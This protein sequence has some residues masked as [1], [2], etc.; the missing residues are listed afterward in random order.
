LRR[1]GSE[2]MNVSTEILASSP[3]TTEGTKRSLCLI[4]FAEDDSARGA[5]HA[6]VTAWRIRNLVTLAKPEITFMVMISAGFA[7]L[8]ASN[9][10]SIVVLLKTM[11]GTGLL[12]GGAGALNQYFERGLD[13]RMRRTARR[14]LPSGKVTARAALFLG[15][16]L[17]LGGTIY[18][19]LSLNVL[20]ALL[21]FFTL[22]TYVFVYTPLKTRTTLSTVVGAIPGAAPMLMGW[23][24]A[25]NGLAPMAWVLFFIL[26]F[27]QFPHFY[28]IGWLYREDYARAGMKMLPAID[29]DGGDETFRRIMISTQLLIFA[30][31]LLAFIASLGAVYLV[32]GLSLGLGFYYVAYRAYL[33]RSRLAAKTLLHASVLYLPLLYIVILLDRL[34]LS[35]ATR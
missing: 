11:L 10:F 23:A 7:C 20:T 15:V 13:A 33:S 2:I 32:L 22:V 18:L 6:S 4:G 30:S 14:P 12:A 17:A 29:V 16:S 28:A 25:R 9:S 24:A 27:W 34:Y 31:F 21:G 8:M 19:I 26:L 5:P 3:G 1:F 35:V